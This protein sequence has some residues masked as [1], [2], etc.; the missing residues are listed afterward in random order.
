MDDH[1]L[2]QH[3]EEANAELDREI[4]ETAY[5]HET[6]LAAGRRRIVGVNLHAGEHVS[7]PI[8][9]IDK[10]VEKGQVAALKRL[11]RERDGA[12]VEACLKRLREAARACAERYGVGETA[13][14]LTDLYR[15][16]VR[17]EA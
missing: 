11:R 2:T 9:K 5:R 16:L 7:P 1:K 15:G 10:G 12:R 8:L 17:S 4:A 14:Q 6:E 13:K 3:I